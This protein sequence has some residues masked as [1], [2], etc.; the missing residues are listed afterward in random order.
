MSISEYY[1]EFIDNVGDECLCGCGHKTTWINHAGG[2][3][4]DYVHGHNTAGKTKEIDAGAARRSLIM[5]SHYK[6][7]RL[8]GFY[9]TPNAEICGRARQASTMRE[10]VKNGTYQSPNRFKTVEQLSEQ[11]QRAFRTRIKNNSFFG[12]WKKIHRGWYTSIKAGKVYYQSSWERLYMEKLDKDIDVT[13]WSRCTHKIDYLDP[14]S[15][16]IRNYYPDFCVDLTSDDRHIFEVKGQVTQ[17]D[18]AKFA[19]AQKIYNDKFHVIT[20]RSKTKKWEE[21]GI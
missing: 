5:K 17:I 16:K 4:T 7:G 20:Y 15:N 21:V 14:I 6:S 1:L 19:A 12:G 13:A 3:F 18:V 11:S 8:R 10:R 9:K 2:R